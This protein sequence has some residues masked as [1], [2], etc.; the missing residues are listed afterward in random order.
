MDIRISKIISI[1]HFLLITFIIFVTL[2]SITLFITL[3]N[4]IVLKELKFSHLEFQDIHL[5]C[6]DG[7]SLHVENI[8]LSTDKRSTQER[9]FAFSNIIDSLNKI[10]KI[11]PLF[12]NIVIQSLHV[13]NS[14]AHLEYKKGA[15]LFVSFKNSKFLL[16]ATVELTPKHL[17]ISSLKLNTLDNFLHVSANAL[18]DRNAQGVYAQLHSSILNRD[19]QTIYLKGDHQ[20]IHFN[21][22]FLSPMSTLTEIVNY[23]EL[24]EDIRPWI[25]TYPVGDAPIMESLSGYIPYDN[26]EQLLETLQAKAH[27]PNVAY[28]FQKGFEPAKSKRVDLSFNNGILNI[29]PRKA[30]WYSHHGEN[31]SLAI[32][33]KPIDPILTVH[34]DTTTQFD[35]VLRDLIHSFGIDIP[36]EQKEGLTEADL[37]LFVNLETNQVNADG[38][39]KLL[40]S[41]VS[42]HNV[43]Y[44]VFSGSVTIKDSDVRLIDINTSYQN[45][46]NGILNGY[47]QAAK[48]LGKL[49]IDLHAI[50]LLDK[51]KVSL[52]QKPLHVS[53]TLLPH[54]DDKIMIAPS[55]WKA[56]GF[57]LHVKSIQSDFNYDKLQATLP[58]TPIRIKEAVDGEI[59]GKIDIDKEIYDLNL[60][61]V[62]LDLFNLQLNQEHLHVKLLYDEN[63]SIISEHNSSWSYATL[64]LTI[65]K[66]DTSINQETLHVKESGFV[67]NND[68]QSNLNGKLSFSDSNGSF[69]LDNIIVKND[70]IGD[71][72]SYEASIPLLLSFEEKNIDVSIPR[73]DFSIRT[74]REGW[75]LSIPDISQLE[76]YSKLMQD[77][78]ISKGSLHIGKT[79]KRKGL[80]FAGIIDYHYPFLVQ[81]NLPQ[82]HYDFY[83]NYENQRTY[84]NV[85]NDLNIS[86]DNSIALTCKDVG[87]NLSAFVDFI[88]DHNRTESKGSMPF[89]LHA[90]DSYIYFSKERK[91]LADTLKINA[92][93]DDVFAS[94]IYKKGGAGLEM[95]KDEFYL[96]GQHFN[97][98]FMNH[99]LSLSEHEGGSFSFAV[100]G[101]LDKFRGVARIDD[102]RIKDYVLLNNVLAFVNTIPSLASFALPSYAKNGIKIN[103]A[104]TAFEYKEDLMHFNA[105]KFDSGE[106]DLFGSGQADYLNNAIDVELNLKTH[107]GKNV[108]QLPV[109]GYILVGDDG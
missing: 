35:T 24:H 7:L 96:Y 45:Y 86:I 42:F 85:N 3:Q 8:L 99:F 81:N 107:L 37:K 19:R 84:I 4:G 105:V 46:A 47:I 30:Q 22:K 11:L 87:M 50:T 59:Q 90:I 73:L 13:S 60:T 61:L 62:K 91:A 52:D 94:I 23:A 101:S 43:D 92:K 18:I 48:N 51:A 9:R 1:I 106:V 32:D 83:G 66:F 88:Q 74:F 68:L 57:P 97:D 71:I 28:T 53:Y 26:P 102:T 95:H 36:L 14:I 33:L 5:S 100:K 25:I 38:R 98:N 12:E 69:Q 54:R 79:L 93:D 67:L 41:M 89:T 55:Q 34:V 109:V 20:G 64:P 80:Y 108:S 75:E 2:L 103:E 104:Y 17:S 39:F 49:D 16:D 63:L 15:P 29:L 27:W 58:S 76:P 31:T 78:N 65:S 77:Y 72:L 44:K 40:R 70:K 21:T 82:Y 10:E 6:E 56:F